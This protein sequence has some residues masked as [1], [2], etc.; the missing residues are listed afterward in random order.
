MTDKF[1]QLVERLSKATEAND[2]EAIAKIDK[3][4]DDML[5]RLVSKHNKKD[6][7]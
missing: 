1:E 7:V 2:K 3:E 4:F 5:S 6:A